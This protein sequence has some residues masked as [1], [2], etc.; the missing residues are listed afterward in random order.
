MVLYL[1]QIPNTQGEVMNLIDRLEQLEGMLH[2][3]D[4]N[5]QKD[6]DL[7]FQITEEMDDIEDAIR[8]MMMYDT[9]GWN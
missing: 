7:I 1:M 9:N 3:L 6:M 2:L 8:D 4:P 5:N